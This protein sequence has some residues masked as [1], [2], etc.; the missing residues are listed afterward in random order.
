MDTSE[1]VVNNSVIPECAIGKKLSSKCH[2]G[3]FYLKNT[4]LDSMHTLPDDQ[5]L[6][7]T[8]RSEV[9]LTDDDQICLHHKAKYLDM[10]EM[11]QKVCCNPFEKKNHVVKSGLSKVDLAMSENFRKVAKRNVKP[12]QKI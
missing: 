5:R 10:Y 6:L 11:V 3:A 2:H 8:L 9:K 12:G 4:G 1:Q 7:I